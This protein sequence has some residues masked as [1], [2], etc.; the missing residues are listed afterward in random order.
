MK[1]LLSILLCIAML[2]QI[3]SVAVWAVES[4][5]VL[6]GGT[7][8]ANLT[9]ELSED[10]V[11]TISG[12][13]AME[14]YDME[15]STAPWGTWIERIEKIIIEEGVST[16]GSYAFVG[17]SALEKVEAAESVESIGDHAF[18]DFP[19]LTPCMLVF[20]GDAMAFTEQSFSDCYNTCGVY[21]ADKLGWETVVGDY[22]ANMPW[23]AMESDGTIDTG[24]VEDNVTWKLNVD[25]TLFMDGEGELPYAPYDLD[26]S[27]TGLVIENG[28]TSIASYAFC[29]VGNLKSVTIPASVTEIGERAFDE[30]MNLRE[31][32]FEGNAPTIG[33]YAFSYAGYYDGATVYYPA[34]NSTWTEDVRQSYGGNLTWVEREIEAVEDTTPPVITLDTPDD[35]AFVRGETTFTVTAS[36]DIGLSQIK[37]QRPDADADIRAVSGT[38]A[39]EEFTID[40]TGMEEG[41]TLT[42]YFIAV[43]T[44]DNQ[45]EITCTF[46]VDN[47]DEPVD[48]TAP[49]ITEV[50]P[51]T[52]DNVTLCHDGTLQIAASDDVELAYAEFYCDGLLIGRADFD[53]KG[54]AALTWD[55]SEISGDATLT[56][57]VYD[58]AGNS[59]EANADVAIRAY[60]APETPSNL[61]VENAYRSAVL[62]WS[63]EGDLQ[64]LK[65]FN[66]YDG[67]EDGGMLVAVVKDYK[68]TFRD[69]EEACSY[70]IAAVDIYGNQSFST[71]PITVTPILTEKEAP[72]A[73]LPVKEMTGVT[74]MAITFSGASSTDNDKIASYEWD[75]GDGTTGAGVHAEHTYA[76][77]GTYIV[78]LTVIDRS[79]NEDSATATVT[80]YDTLGA[81]ATHAVLTVTVMDGYTENTPAVENATVTVYSEG[82]EIAAKTDSNGQAVM[83]VPN[84][85]HT[86]TV[87]KNGYDGKAFE[88]TVSPDANG[89]MAR[90]VYLAESGVKILGGELTA[91]PMTYEE[92]VEAGIDVTDPANNHV[93]K[94][95]F[96]IRY[97]PTPELA[98]ELPIEQLIN[99]AGEMLKGEGFG[100][101]TFTPEPENLYPD[102]PNPD[103]PD[104]ITP[105]DWGIPKYDVG[106]YPVGESAYM[107]IY[108]QSHWLKE[109]FNVEL[110]VFNN[111]YAED[112]TDCIAELQL[113]EGLSLAT[114][115]E[116]Q[117]SESMYI[118]MIEH[119]EDGEPTVRQVNWYVRGD[120][121]GDYKLTAAV[122][123]YVGGDPF[124]STFTTEDSIHVYAGSALK[125]FVTMPKSA[126]SDKEYSVKFSLQN[127]SDKPIYN[128][129][130]GLDS[131]QQFTA[132]RMSDDTLGDVKREF[133]NAD[134]EDRMTYGLPVLE[135]GKAF[136]IVLT[137]T[138]AY[139][140][141][142]VEWAVGNVPGAEVGY[143][144]ADVFVTTLDGSTT[145]IPVE[146]ILEDVEKDSL[147]QWIWDETLG[148]L[149]DKGKEV[150]I[151]FIDDKVFKGVP[152]VEKG[153]EYFELFK[154]IK[155]TVEEDDIEYKPTV[156]VTDG[157]QCV[158]ESEVDEYLAMFDTYSLRRRSVPGVIVWTD[159]ADA[160]IS[161][162]GSTMTMPS[163]G[164]L[165][166][167]R[168]GETANTPEIAVTT[169]YVDGEGKVQEFTRTL[170]TDQTYEPGL[171]E[172]QHI[173]M[174]EL[175]ENTFAVPEEDDIVEVAFSGYLISENG[176]IL[177]RASNQI[178]TIT[179]E[180]GKEAEGMT[181]MNG[182]LVIDSDAKAGTYTVKLSLDGTDAVM[183]QQIV[184][185]KDD[186]GMEHTCEDKDHDHACDYGCD[187]V[188]GEHEDADSDHACDICGAENITDH[189]F[190]RAWSY[191]ADAHWHDAACG[192]DVISDESAHEYGND[193]TCDVCGYTKPDD[194]ILPVFPIIPPH[195]D[196]MANKEDDS[197]VPGSDIP[198]AELPWQNPFTDVNES[199]WFYEDVKYMSQK[200]IMIGTDDT[201]F[202]PDATLTRAMLVT[203]LWR[204]EGKP[205][206]NYIMPFADVESEQWYTEAIRWAAAER[207]VKGYGNGE[208]GT[209]DAVTREQVMAILHRYAARKEQDFG[210]ILPMIPQYE[211]SIWAE[212][213]LLWADMAGL[214]E[215]IGADIFDMT[216]EASRAEI[217][218]YMK[219]FCEGVY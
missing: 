68:Y 136:E 52:E 51:D 117:Q 147:I 79:G 205:V 32:I 162:D 88:I 185:T 22:Y 151:E 59:A 113:P 21:M 24:A 140:H 189:S 106:V 150:V 177:L 101:H 129:S 156:S 107:V 20:Y 196:D 64:T 135:P 211:Y 48:T 124:E 55:C 104:L 28:I 41:S 109:M 134:F 170:T 54:I 94:Q 3:C 11:L 47:V 42:L 93:V 197:D 184:L 193:R 216:K 120:T 165:Y 154:D 190:S 97:Q 115:L 139:E 145:D 148:A 219:R 201:T 130:F 38:T 89:E 121:E 71:D 99:A 114:M 152:V 23:K 39:T 133:S 143:R 82:F 122:H 8:G 29:M 70:K 73:V 118:G 161:E 80:V 44:S 76:K 7:C 108:G 31:I 45:T 167:L 144:V 49:V 66:I 2:M 65:Q 61:K 217:A 56:Y 30:C 199:D 207:I 179:D 149:K 87:V 37:L 14:N 137:T 182:V 160:E 110:I 172:A 33:E 141:Q 186:S 17:C 119:I 208:F 191:D 194:S 34:D 192:H 90:D 138:F 9:W 166:V 153:V 203:V 126:Y 58:T 159:A 92:I 78:K 112:M 69:L 128:L 204:L 98:F 83:V 181:M 100:W 180:N 72:V 63:Y 18:A 200:G 91:K 95:E 12:S 206:V 43:D 157:V 210:M 84:A 4:E 16:I 36:D 198:S 67:E 175:A 46:I 50:W 173:L 169:Y 131:A 26:V 102:R 123:G 215:G 142:F 74:G 176:D 158:P 127:V 202:A 10:Y 183:E 188:F 85:T 27:Y 103:K 57:I 209:N 116:S 178:W 155:D 174:D 218:A 19:G 146:I 15:E 5:D 75:F 164:K 60:E 96:T 187:K 163:G 53:A 62:S 40:T 81:D 111:S 168:L 77:S 125:L 6:S 212:N 105:G 86:M 213:D 1:K 195:T 171:K 25:G 132:Q 35:G 13:G 214:T